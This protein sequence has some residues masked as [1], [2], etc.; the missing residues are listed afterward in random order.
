VITFAVRAF[1]DCQQADISKARGC[2]IYTAMGRVGVYIRAAARGTRGSLVTWF[3]EAALTPD[4]SVDPDVPRCAIRA[5]SRIVSDRS[6]EVLTA[7]ARL[8]P[9]KGGTQIRKLGLGTQLFPNLRDRV[10]G[11]P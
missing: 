7:Q 4:V 8:R 10:S 11:S 9:H 5:S 1:R 2:G 3:A 6:P